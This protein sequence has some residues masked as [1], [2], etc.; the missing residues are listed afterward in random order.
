MA[1]LTSF[2]IGQVV[3]LLIAGTFSAV[4]PKLLAL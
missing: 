3:T 4:V 2:G 1:L